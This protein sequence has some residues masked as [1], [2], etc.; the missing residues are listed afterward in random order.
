M[1]CVMRRSGGRRAGVLMVAVAV[2]ALIGIQALPATADARADEERFVELINAERRAHGVGGL[3]VHPELVE[4]ARRHAARMAAEGRIFHSDDLAEGLDDWNLLGENVGRG[5]NIETLHQ[6]FMDSPGHR[7]NL[8]NPVYDLV[9]IGVVW[10]EGIPYVVEVFMDP[11]EELRVQFSPPFS[12]DDGSVHE[13]DI[14]ALYERGITRGCDDT[15]YCPERPVTRGEMASLLVRSFGLKGSPGDIFGD[16]NASVHES[17]IETLAANGI[18][19][20]CAPGRFCPDRGVTRGEMATFLT[21]I[22]DLPA[23]SSAGFKDIAGSP[24]AA[25]I[26]SLAASGITKGCTATTFCPNQGVTRAQVASFLV[27]ALQG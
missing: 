1:N 18:T 2:I 17:A 10:S 24:H 25:A 7:D 3:V 12:D 6:A 5:G 15:R 26:N 27:R 22:L 21:R 8:L 9:G 14:V 19:S 13:V 16:D 11:I 4:K 23:A 20:G